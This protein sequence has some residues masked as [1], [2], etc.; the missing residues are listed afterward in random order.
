MRIL[1]FQKHFR[2]DQTSVV[3]ADIGT[4]ERLLKVN[5]QQLVEITNYYHL[6]ILINSLFRLIQITVLKL[7]LL[8]TTVVLKP[9]PQTSILKIKLFIKFY[10]ATIIY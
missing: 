5:K 7:K 4:T 6:A 9:Y 3:T 1:D 2:I 10:Q 8:P